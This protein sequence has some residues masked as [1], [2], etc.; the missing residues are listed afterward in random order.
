MTNV[1]ILCLKRDAYAY[2]A[3]NKNETFFKELTNV[4]WDNLDYD[5]IND[6]IGDI[7]TDKKIR[8]IDEGD[9]IG[10]KTSTGKQGILKVVTTTIEHNPYNATT[11]I[12]DVKMQ[13]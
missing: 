13:K 12:F 4:D 9:F 8:G 10:F 2:D 1:Q 11:I 7:G 5:G 3:S 6:A